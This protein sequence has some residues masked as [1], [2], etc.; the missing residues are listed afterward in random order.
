ML[1]KLLYSLLTYFIDKLIGLITSKWEDYQEDEK[2]KEE[3]KLK[4][5]AIKNAKTKEEFRTAIR[6]LSI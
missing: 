2:L 1:E 4:V 5:K 3:V 6:D